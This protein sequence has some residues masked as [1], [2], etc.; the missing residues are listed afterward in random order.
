MRSHFLHLLLYSTLVSAFFLL[1]SR[2]G[3][4]ESLR[5]GLILWSAMVFGALAVAFLMLPFPR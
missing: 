1:L 4:R 5:F 3:S 2:R